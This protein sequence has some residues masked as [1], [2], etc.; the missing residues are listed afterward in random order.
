MFA[1]FHEYPKKY[2]FRFLS[3]LAHMFLHQKIDFFNRFINLSIFEKDEG[4]K[5]VS[6]WTPILLTT[7]DYYAFSQYFLIPILHDLDPT[8]EIDSSCLTIE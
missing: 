7:Y 8:R 5:L 3:L 4:C 1:Q 6:T 2:Q